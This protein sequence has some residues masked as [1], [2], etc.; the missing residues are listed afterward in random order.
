MSLGK[1]AAPVGLTKVRLKTR[2]GMNGYVA[3]KPSQTHQQMKRMPPMTSM[4]MREAV[5]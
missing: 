3:K 4:A 2:R 5:M 1:S